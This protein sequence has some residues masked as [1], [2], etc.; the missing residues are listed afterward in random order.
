MKPVIGWC[1]LL[2]ATAVS[3]ESVLPLSPASWIGDHMILPAGRTVLI[4]GV[5]APETKV[6]VKF[7]SQK[8]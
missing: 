3:A 4:R 2:L 7:A 8:K 6:T 1:W 5:A